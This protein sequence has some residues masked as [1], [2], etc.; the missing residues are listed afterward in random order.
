MTLNYHRL[1]LVMLIITALLAVL[2]FS[3]F[4]ADENKGLVPCDTSTTPPCQPCHFVVLL[5]RLTNYMVTRIAIPIAILMLMYAGFVFALAGGSPNR[6]AAGKKVLTNTLIGILIVFGAYFIVDTAIKAF[7]GDFRS[8]SSGGSNFLNLGSK[9]GPWNAPTI[10]TG[11]GHEK[12]ENQAPSGNLE[13]ATN[14]VRD[15]IG[16]IANIFAAFLMGLSVIMILWSAFTYITSGGNTE[17]I[18][19]ARQIL[20]FALI[21]VAVAAVA[22]TLPGLIGTIFS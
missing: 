12:P 20:V 16:R 1:I 9:F 6:I 15:V 5:T 13:Q 18:T 17:K 3:A 22:F 21:G 14:R 19:Q 7:T 2:P 8:I 11:C 4:G 10:S